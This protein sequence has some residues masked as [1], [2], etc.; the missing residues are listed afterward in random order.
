MM[1]ME[2]EIEALLPQI[3]KSYGLWAKGQKIGEKREDSLD[4]RL[5][6]GF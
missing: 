6:G 3:E 5:V 2:A 4:K 1:I